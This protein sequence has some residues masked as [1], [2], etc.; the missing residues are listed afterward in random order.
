MSVTIRQITSRKDF[1]RF[2]E[3]PNRLYKG[4]PWYVP[5]LTSDVVNAL[6]PA[7]NPAYEFCEAA[8]F[9]AYRDD[10]I[11]GRI[12]AIL[13]HRANEYWNHNE[14]RFGWIDFIDDREVSAALIGAVEKF[15]REKGADSLAGPLGFTDFDPEG[16]VVEGFDQ[17]STFTLHFN[18]PY[19]MEH[20]EAM[21]FGKVVDWLEY[22]VFIPKET[23]EKILRIAEYVEQ[24]CNVRVRKITKRELKRENLGRKVFELINRTYINLFDFTVLTDKM[25]D[26]YIKSYFPFL[27]M[28]LVTLIE[29]AEGKLIGCGISMPSITRALQKAKGH[30]LP[31]G[32]YHI[33]KSLFWKHEDSVELLL[34][35]VEPEYANKGLNSLLFRDLIPI[36][37]QYGFKYAETNAELEY[38]NQVRA[39]WELFEADQNKRRRVYGKKL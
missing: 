28:K 9:L 16:M 35:A 1:K 29:D 27:D 22:K 31:F 8:I 4:C 26:A 34:I 11:V 7:K 39:P 23:P 32:W 25:I 37:N 3:F 2:A 38:N 6:D 10:E 30:L 14:V 36:Y 24:R 19:Y 33:L 21:G 13:N 15:A 20:L 12:A 5:Q 18:Y 17:I